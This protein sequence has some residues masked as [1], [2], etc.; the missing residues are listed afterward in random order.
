M[1]MTDQIAAQGVLSG[2]TLWG[3]DLATWALILTFIMAVAAIATAI[4]AKRQNKVALKGLDLSK[5][6]LNF[7]VDQ[8]IAQIL[9][10]LHQRWHS[11]EL[12][13][14]RDKVYR[15]LQEVQND[16]I[17][18]NPD[19]RGD[20]VAQEASRFCPTRLKA[21]S[22]EKIDD[23]RQMMRVVGFCELTGYLVHAGYIPE[24]D[25]LEL[26]GGAILTV[27]TVFEDHITNEIQKRPT[28]TGKEFEHALSLIKAAQR[29][30]ADFRRR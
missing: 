8:H 27:G 15:L 7:A 1:T 10:T 28:S 26:L 5:V 17:E 22:S 13:D 30:E 3:V 23:Y 11:Q 9:V 19:M 18:R 24:R 14:S 4:S 25:M 6:G 12:R 2:I 16:I 20:M 29:M 21:L